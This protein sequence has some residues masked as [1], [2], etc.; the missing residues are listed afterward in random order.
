MGAFDSKLG[1]GSSGS[2]LITARQQH[3]NDILIFER[4]LTTPTSCTH[5]CPL[6]VANSLT[7]TAR[8][9]LCERYFNFWKSSRRVWRLS[10]SSSNKNTLLTD[11]LLYSWKQ[12]GS[13]NVRSHF[14]VIQCNMAPCRAK[15]YKLK[16]KNSHSNN[17]I[18]YLLW[19]YLSFDVTFNTICCSWFVA[20]DWP[21][22]LTDRPRAFI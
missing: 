1:G 15:Y 17:S 4:L 22:R 12:S 20:M 18:K 16:L 19:F 6:D 13:C 3:V 8:H 9:H 11:E 5:T 14:S 2:E 10:C 7:Q 21:I